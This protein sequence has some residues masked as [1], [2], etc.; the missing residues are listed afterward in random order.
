MK[1][2]KRTKSSIVTKKSR[3]SV[4]G[5]GRKTPHDPAGENV[6][7]NH[8]MPAIRINNLQLTCNMAGCNGKMRSSGYCTAHTPARYSQRID[9][10]PE[11]SARL[12]KC[13]T[14]DFREDNCGNV[15]RYCET[16]GV[17]VFRGMMNNCAG[18]CKNCWAAPFW[19]VLSTFSELS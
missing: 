1:C 19:V 10:L 8:K 2:K 7:E 5:C 3:C 9:F 12:N 18:V 15:C 11:N 6:C 16:I 14:A 4:V 13:L 17:G